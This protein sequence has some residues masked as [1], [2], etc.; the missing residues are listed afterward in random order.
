MKKK[1]RTIGSPVGCESFDTVLLPHRSSPPLK[2]S[3]DLVEALRT[4]SAG[5]PVS[6]RSMANASLTVEST[7]AS[8]AE[9]SSVSRRIRLAAFINRYTERYV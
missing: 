1:K 7:I 8:G 6:Y 4:T 3:P 2:D 5:E 9:C